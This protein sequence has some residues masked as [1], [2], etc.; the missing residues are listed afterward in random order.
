MIWLPIEAHWSQQFFP[1]L[2]WTPFVAALLFPAL[3]A[4]ARLSKPSW[5]SR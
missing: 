1:L 3:A 4:L 2:P 5:R